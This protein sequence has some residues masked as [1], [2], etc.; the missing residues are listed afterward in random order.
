M[1]VIALV[2]ST[3]ATH[4]AEGAAITTGNITTGGS[5]HTT[6]CSIFTISSKISSSSN[7]TIIGS[8]NVT[9]SEININ[10]NNTDNT[11]SY[12]IS[13]THCTTICGNTNVTINSDHNN[14]PCTGAYTTLQVVTHHTSV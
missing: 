7:V 3:S 12:I 1:L 8:N 5:N 11:C 2:R 14:N 13:G 9:I 6:G 4:W 10:G